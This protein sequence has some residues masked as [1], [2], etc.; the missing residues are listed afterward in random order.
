MVRQWI[1]TPSCAGSNPAS[2]VFLLVMSIICIK[3]HSVYADVADK[4]KE[5]WMKNKLIKSELNVNNN[6]VSVIRI[7][8]EE[9]ISLT[10]LA[11]YADEDEPRYPIQNWMRNKDVISFL[12]LW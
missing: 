5:A 1:L 6:K 10:D 2:L 3:Y 8:T 12:G 11:R 7:G 9:Y 4:E